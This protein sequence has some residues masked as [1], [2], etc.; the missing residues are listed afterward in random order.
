MDATTVV[1]ELWTRTQARDWTGVTELIAPDAV[2]D[3][4]VSGERFVGRDNYV[5]MNREYPEGWEI[6][7]LRVI[8][9]GDE[10]VTEVEVP[11]ET[12]GTFRVVSLWTVRDGQIVRGT[13]YWTEP[14]SD[15]PREDRAAYTERL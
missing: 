11:H 6:R 14:G 12:M 9:S 13:E 3:W 8:G 5:T 10:A 4:P 2:I 1:R 15:K 7:I